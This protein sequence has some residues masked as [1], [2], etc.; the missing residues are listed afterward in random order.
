MTWY[1]NSTLVAI[2]LLPINGLKAQGAVIFDSA[3]MEL[4]GVT[5]EYTMTQTENGVDKMNTR[6]L[7]YQQNL[8][9]GSLVQS[10]QANPDSITIVGTYYKFDPY[11]QV[12]S[13]WYLV[14]ITN[15]KDTARRITYRYENYRPERRGQ[16]LANDAFQIDNC[17]YK[18]DGDTLTFEIHTGWQLQRSLHD[19]RRDTSTYAGDGSSRNEVLTMVTDFDP[20]SLFVLKLFRSAKLIPDSSQLMF[21]AEPSQVVSKHVKIV[22]RGTIASEMLLT[23]IANAAYKV[24]PTTLSPLAPGDSIE[25]IV[26][27]QSN[28]RGGH[29]DTLFL[30]DPEGRPQCIVDLQG[31]VKGDQ[32]LVRTSTSR[33]FVRLS[34]GALEFRGATGEVLELYSLTGK[35]VDTIESNG[36]IFYLRR[37]THLNG[38]YFFR[39]LSAGRL[40][41]LG[42][43]LIY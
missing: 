17:P 28:T 19:V 8:R 16:S 30:R 34:N 39:N 26:S 4:L 9:F 36:G 23:D 41:Q 15:G 42:K 14:I 37:R 6:E 2:L 21:E 18:S 3:H 27:F 7:G 10:F 13:K 12:S 38:L 31:I 20:A 24:T 1:F 40:V 32:L 43:I 5:A 11:Y 25:L 33:D 22:N 29:R 35:K